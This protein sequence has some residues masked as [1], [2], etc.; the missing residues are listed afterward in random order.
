M[1]GFWWPGRQVVVVLPLGVLAVSW[2]LGTLA[3]RARRV[4]PTG[5]AVLGAAS[6]AMY[7][8]LVVAGR[9]GELQWVNAPDWTGGPVL[10]ALRAVLPDYREDGATTWILHAVWA[11]ALVA[12]A[13]AAYRGTPPAEAR[14]EP[15]HENQPEPMEETEC[16][17]S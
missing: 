13:V 9:A 7:V 15:T 12:L 17:T 10:T 11:A 14:P 16:V 3:G 2:W 6:V 5:A 4:V 8:R 1:H